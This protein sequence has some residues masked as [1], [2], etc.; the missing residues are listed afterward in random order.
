M[1]VKP[2]L[3]GAV[4]H[5]VQHGVII[6]HMAR[7][8]AISRRFKRQTFIREWRLYRNLTQAQLVARLEEMGGP[9]VPK[10]VASLSRLENGV[11]PYS[12]PLLEAL[13]DI[14]QTDPGSLLMRNPSVDGYMWSIWD[15]AKTG[16]REQI[17]RVAEAIVDYKAAGNG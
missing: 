10:T 2:L 11:Q 13:A 14:L 6:R 3:H 12:Q 17:T 4:F 8:P 5:P 15:Q 16:E 7:K 1:I 9:D